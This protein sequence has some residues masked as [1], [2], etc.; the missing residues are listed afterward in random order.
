MISKVF[1]LTKPPLYENSLPGAHTNVFS[2]L[3]RISSLLNLQ[4]FYSLSLQLVDYTYM[5][6]QCT[7]LSF[8]TLLIFRHVVH[9][10]GTYLLTFSFRTLPLYTLMLFFTLFYRTNLLYFECLSFYIK[11]FI[12]Y[13]IIIN[14]SL[15]HFDHLIVRVKI[16]DLPPPDTH[17]LLEGKLYFLS[18]RLS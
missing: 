6:F 10:N 12:L 9:G 13:L 2:Q 17:I 1:D 15:K 7:L 8:R 14:L 18:R 5:Y 3:H 11:I 4:F 16:L